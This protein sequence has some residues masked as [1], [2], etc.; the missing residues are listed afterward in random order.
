MPRPRARMLLRNPLPEENPPWSL[1]SGPVAA[2]L[3]C[4]GRCWESIRPGKRPSWCGCGRRMSCRKGKV[5]LLENQVAERDT[6][7][8]AM[9]VERQRAD[10]LLKDRDSQLPAERCAATKA[11]STWRTR[12][13]KL[14]DELEAT[15]GQRGT[16]RTAPEVVAVQD[17][18]A[19]DKA[20]LTQCAV[21]LRT[22]LQQAATAT[23]LLEDSLK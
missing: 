17:G 21:E 20:W 5:A 19:E 12:E 9:R 22:G 13:K 14:P 3:R 1:G 2:P 7:L 6:Q 15:R 23:A 11:E 10:A 4:P 16:K 8:A 18:V